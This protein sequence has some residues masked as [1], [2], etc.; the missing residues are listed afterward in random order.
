[1]K[2][3]FCFIKEE[4]EEGASFA[5]HALLLGIVT[6]AIVALIGTLSSRIVI[7]ISNTA[8]GIPT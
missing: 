4:E 2:N 5:E 6:A 3:M 8:N 7:A 1:M